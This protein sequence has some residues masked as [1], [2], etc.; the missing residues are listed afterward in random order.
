MSVRQSAECLTLSVRLS[1]E[2]LL[3]CV[4]S[5]ESILMSVKVPDFLLIS[6]KQSPEYLLLSV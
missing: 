3:L 4:K 1:P 2:R 5:P 6:V